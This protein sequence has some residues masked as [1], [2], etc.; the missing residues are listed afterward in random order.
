MKDLNIYASVILPLPLSG[1]FTYIANNKSVE[2]G[3]RVVV[4][5]GKAKYYVGVVSKLF[6]E[7]PKIENLKSI[8]S[9]I[10]DKPIISDQLINLWKWISNYYMC[11]LGDVLNAAIPGGL[12]LKSEQKLRFVKTDIQVKGELLNLI[13]K[14][15]EIL[16]KDLEGL[17]PSDDLFKEINDLVAN[18]LVEIL[19][20]VEKYFKP[21]TVK[22]V[23]LNKKI[24]LL[25]NRSKILDQLK[26]A[27]KQKLV[28]QTLFNN[29]QVLLQDLIE[30][31]NTSQLVIKELHKKQFIEI[32]NKEIY[33][34]NNS[35][36]FVKPKLQL[37][38]KQEEAFEKIKDSFVEK[39]PVLLHGVTSSGKTEVYIKLISEI[40]KQNNQVL[41]L[42]PE[43]ALTS[44][45]INR[46]RE[47]FGNKI[48]VY[49]SRLNSNEKI[50]VWNRINKI[51]SDFN[52]VLGAR[53]SIFLP[54]KKLKLI[55]VDE[56]H[57]TSYKQFDPSP[58]YNSRDVAVYYSRKINANIVL[59]SATPSIESYYNASIGKYKLV[60]LTQ[61][62]KN[63]QLPRVECIDIAYEYKRRRM[64]AHFSNLLI[65]RIGEAID[66]K[67]QVILFQN[68]RGYAPIQEC[69]SCGFV[70]KC[71]NCDVSLTMHFKLNLLRCHYC[72]YSEPSNSN[73]H[74]CNSKEINSLGFG[75]EK[76]EIE[77]KSIFPD[78][79]IKR[80]DYD[81]TRGKDSYQQI[82]NKFEKGKIDILIGTQ[83]LTKG[84]HF[85]NVNLVGVLNA[86]SI[87]NYPD[88]RADERGFQLLTQV[89][90]RAGRSTKQGLVL[91][92]TYNL[93]NSILKNVITSD[94]IN[95]FYS[96]I[97]ER[98]MLQY[99][100]YFSFI[101][102]TLKHK[103]K[104]IVDNAAHWLASQL[105][106]Q[107]KDMIMGPV[108][109]P[110]SRVKNSYLKNIYMRFN[111][112]NHIAI[113][114]FLL[115]LK[116]LLL[117]SKEFGS[118]RVNFDVDPL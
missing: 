27:P 54:F 115:D 32:V 62:Y 93:D 5:F 10:D 42:L 108:N 89:S 94:Y 21:R 71:K 2:V 1:E 64:Q 28:L 72:G 105:K 7:K 41:Y 101:K 90:G 12:K 98:K 61:R 14:K 117:S 15:R 33:R 51:E 106:D 107:I 40:I 23:Q 38:I 4:P 8:E 37:S 3:K 47:H 11:S 17:Y 55:I 30:Q 92:Q 63:I 34:F 81:T 82:I 99:P 73:C 100:P 67:E 44:Q 52:V 104:H 78:V 58:R 79:I 88:F 66:N 85:N 29:N 13:K 56:E 118:V 57:D 31:T 103:N 77:L 113:K 6:S 26:S 19:D 84:L 35:E 43:I 68:R 39:K 110:V 65:E 48:I 46:L 80:M 83:M 86:D 70:P 116:S 96:Q 24:A 95:F 53:S 74:S 18:G 109:P 91:M 20:K 50:E 97:Q 75:T 59:G 114:S 69:S 76:V 22:L 16:I 111:K 49:H 45:M 25:K 60:E 112:K 36:T 87:L 9:I 102:I